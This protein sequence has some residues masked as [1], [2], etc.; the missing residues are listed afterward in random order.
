MRAIGRPTA[1]TD[2]LGKRISSR[3]PPKE[4]STSLVTFSVSTSNN[5]SPT[6][7]V[8]PGLRCQAVIRPSV[9][10]SPNLGITISDISFS[11]EIR[12]ALLDEGRAALMSIAAVEDE[13]DHRLLVAQRRRKRHIRPVDQRALEQLQDQRRFCCEFRSH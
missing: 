9:I 4:A 5:R 8:S 1:T 6:F 10:V 2:P 11:L 7:T 13:A 12:R 3:M